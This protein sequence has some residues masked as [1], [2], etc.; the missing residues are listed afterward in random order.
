MT[1]E[2]QRLRKLVEA[3]TDPDVAP[4]VVEKLDEWARVVADARDAIE[5]A[6]LVDVDAH[7]SVKQVAEW[8]NVS[9]DA[10]YKLV[11]SGSL[12]DRRIGGQIRIPVSAVRAYLDENTTVHERPDPKPRKPRTAPADAETIKRYPFLRSV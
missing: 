4:L 2:H 5:R 7:V 10:V 1:T 8:F 12:P 11:Q 9:Y 6:S 3:Y